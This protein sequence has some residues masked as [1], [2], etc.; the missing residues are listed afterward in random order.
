ML[1]IDSLC[2]LHE[3]GAKLSKDMRVRPL[4]NGLNVSK[5]KSL[6][7]LDKVEN[8]DYSAWWFFAFPASC[9]F[10]VGLP[11]PMFFRFDDVEYS[12]RLRKECRVK[13]VTINGIAVWHE[14]FDKKESSIAWF[15]GERNLVWLKAVYFDK[16]S[17]IN[18][19][20]EMLKRIAGRILRFRYES[21]EM[22]LVGM[23]QALRGPIFIS[24]LESENFHEKIMGNMK[25]K[26]FRLKNEL[27][28]RKQRGINCMISIVTPQAAGNLPKRIK[29]ILNKVSRDWFY[30]FLSVISLNGHFLP[31]GFHNKIGED[32]HSQCCTDDKLFFATLPKSIVL[33][34]RNGEFGNIGYI[35]RKMFFQISF[36]TIKTCYK[37]L[38]S[39]IFSE[40]IYKENH[41]EFT[42]MEFWQK[43]IMDP[44]PEEMVLK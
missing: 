26:F 44:P 37:I 25:E 2:E 22:I 28:R 42:S 14:P 9:V 17:R 38:R 34:D 40:N 10:K 16:F 11:L 8:I 3:Y 39:G 23:D 1:R 15:Y 13:I 18:L 29:N 43:K 32:E 12:L 5:K 41:K 4:N 7:A 19:V 27:P 35:S 33:T 20:F 24:D 36:L 31:V 6:L 21:A 30:K